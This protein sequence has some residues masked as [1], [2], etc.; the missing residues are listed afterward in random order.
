MLAEHKQKKNR[1]NMEVI[2]PEAHIK[3]EGVSKKLLK[4]K[5]SKSKSSVYDFV[6]QS[7]NVNKR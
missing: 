2:H 7:T 5:D 3:V 1:R 6:Y 4:A